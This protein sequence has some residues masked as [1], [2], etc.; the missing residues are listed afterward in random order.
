M[1]HSSP[2]PAAPLARRGARRVGRGLQAHSVRRESCDGSQQS[3]ACGALVRRG[4]GVLGGACRRTPCAERAVMAHSSPEPAARWWGGGRVGR[5][6]RRTPCAER[7]VM[8]HS[9]PEPAARWYGGGRERRGRL[10]AHSVRGESCDCSQ[11]SRA[12]GALEGRGR[13]VLGGAGR[14]TPCAER[15]VIA[16]SSPEPAA[17]WWGGDET[18]WVGLAGALRAQGEL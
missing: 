2:E 3:R 17:R 7:A 16:H 6:G 4:R 12:C 18:R 15:A 8:A 10:Q 14:R 1:A 13:G 9:S 5:T 11:Q